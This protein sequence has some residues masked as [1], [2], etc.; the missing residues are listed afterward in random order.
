MRPALALRRA[1]L[2][3]L[4]LLLAACGGAGPREVRYGQENCDQCRMTISDPRFGAQAVTT[5]GKARKFDSVECLAS[6]WLAN[7]GPTGAFEEAWV[8][9]YAKPGSW[10]RTDSARF[11]QG[12]EGHSPMGLG[13]MAFASDADAATQQRRTRGRVLT[14][15]EVLALVE[16]TGDRPGAPS[17]DSAH[18]ETHDAAR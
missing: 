5:K 11:L 3:A 4:A 8:N 10:V 7:G 2:P 12:G 1:A 13:L 6:F 17:H 15:P 14:W 18:A 16:R 9:D